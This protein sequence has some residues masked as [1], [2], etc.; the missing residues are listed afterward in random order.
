LKEE[1]KEELREQIRK[2]L[3]ESFPM[4]ARKQLIEGKNEG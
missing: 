3:I 2:E 1:L 4:E